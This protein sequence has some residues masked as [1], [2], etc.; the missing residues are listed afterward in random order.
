VLDN[1]KPVKPVT[2]GEYIAD[3]LPPWA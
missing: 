2:V 3:E 1:T